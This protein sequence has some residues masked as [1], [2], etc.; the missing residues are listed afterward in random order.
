MLTIR[1]VYLSHI[2][3]WIH[4]NNCVFTT[5]RKTKQKQKRKRKK[6]KKG[7]GGR[8]KKKYEEYRTG[9]IWIAEFRSAFL[10]WQNFICSFYL[11]TSSFCLREETCLRARLRKFVGIESWQSVGAT[12]QRTKPCEKR[13]CS[14]R[15]WYAGYCWR[16]SL[17]ET[18]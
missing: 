6:E 12:R 16:C 8:G 15:R 11:P 4:R 1:F 18:Q 14:R 9:S 10:H 7:G 13:V 5:Y 2:K 3:I 17:N